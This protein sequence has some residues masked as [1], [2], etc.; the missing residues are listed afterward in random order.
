MS[1]PFDDWKTTDPDD[2]ETCEHGRTGICQVC[3]AE[4]RAS[5]H[6][7]AKEERHE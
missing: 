5:Q 1:D 6:D 7:W 4:A 3:L 2:A